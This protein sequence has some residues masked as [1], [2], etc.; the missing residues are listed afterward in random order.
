MRNLI[1]SVA[2]KYLAHKNKKAKQY[3]SKLIDAPESRLYQ[4]LAF[5]YLFGYKR[6]ADKT[7]KE[8]DYDYLR[9][10][11]QSLNMKTS[12]KRL[13]ARSLAQKIQ[14]MENTLEE[15]ICKSIKKKYKGTPYQQ[16]MVNKMPK[17]IKNRFNEPKHR[18]I[19]HQ[20]DYEDSPQEKENHE[21]SPQEKMARVLEKVDQQKMER[22]IA[23]STKYVLSNLNIDAI[24]QYCDL[25][26]QTMLQNLTAEISAEIAFASLYDPKKSI[27][28][29]FDQPAK[30]GQ[31]IVAQGYD[32]RFLNIYIGELILARDNALECIEPIA[33]E[34]LI[35]D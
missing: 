35:G 14:E 25:K 2:I 5:C 34:I 33:D 8:F 11:I 19:K 22:V 21:D 30:T 4:D 13:D 15:N 28:A 20:K 29:C 16:F 17:R 1:G 9:Q 3:A 18:P 10:E 24:S 26:Y 12:S 6:I 31:K 7:L 27:Q 23:E 32:E